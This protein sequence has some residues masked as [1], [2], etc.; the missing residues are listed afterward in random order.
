MKKIAVMPVKNEEWII[1]HTLTCASLF[2]DHIIVADQ[3]SSDRT[4]AICNKFTKVVYIKN[5][6]TEYNEGDRRQ[7]LL[8]AARTFEGNNFI[9]NLAADEVFSANIL[10]QQVF[11][12]LVKDQR[13]GTSFSFH[14]VQLWRS[15]KEFR[16]DNSVWSNSYRPFAFIDDRVTNYKK[17]FAHLSIV[18][19][20]LMSSAVVNNEIKVLHYQFV[21]FER[22]LAKQ[23]WARLLEFEHYTQPDFLKSIILNNKYYITK[24]EHDITLSHVKDEWFSAYNQFNISSTARTWHVDAAID[25]IKKYGANRLVWLDIWDY[26]WANNITD[27]R[28][29]IQKIYHRNQHLILKMNKFAPKPLKA[30]IKKI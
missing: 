6:T 25:F 24:D 9:A 11:D 2:F 20:D 15:D 16:D 14:W 22:M 17:G 5:N 1:E 18:P 13:P 28:N 21:D 12:R 26:D 30:L 10:D 23:R 19:E 3:N 8:D 4:A 7:L 29:I 27:N